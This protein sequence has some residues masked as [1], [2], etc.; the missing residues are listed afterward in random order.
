[1]SLKDITTQQMKEKRESL[2]IDV[3]K[4]AQKAK[5]VVRSAAE[6]NI[7][8]VI[9]NNADKDRQRSKK[10]MEKAKKI[11]LIKRNQSGRMK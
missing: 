2:K 1:M 10:E 3:A 8:V 4:I 11:K 6:R 9:F 5:G 7:Y